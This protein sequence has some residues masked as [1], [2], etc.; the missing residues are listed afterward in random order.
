[1]DWLKVLKKDTPIMSEDSKNQLRVKTLEGIKKEAFRC[2]KKGMTTDQMV[3]PL[4]KNKDF[5]ATLE[6]LGI[7]RENLKRIVEDFVAEYD[8]KQEEVKI[9]N[10]YSFGTTVKEKYEMSKKGARLATLKTTKFFVKKETIWNEFNNFI[11]S[12]EQETFDH[13]VVQLIRTLNYGEKSCSEFKNT[14]EQT[15]N[16]LKRWPRLREFKGALYEWIKQSRIQNGFKE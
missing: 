6:S 4:Y 9:E 1:M 10:E 14:E 7:D 3:Y 12:L 11:N 15:E 8:K 5:M 16:S 13:N 2:C